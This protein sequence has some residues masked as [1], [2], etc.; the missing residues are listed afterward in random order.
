MNRNKEEKNRER[1][2]LC[3][4]C[5]EKNQRTGKNKF[6]DRKIGIEMDGLWRNKRT[7]N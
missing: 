3:Q 2:Q 1:V 6:E 7:M 5:L 4:K